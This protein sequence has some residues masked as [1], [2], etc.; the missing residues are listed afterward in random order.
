MVVSISVFGNK[1][2]VE[3]SDNRQARDRCL[4][5]ESKRILDCAVIKVNKLVAFARKWTELEITVLHKINQL[6]KDKHCMF[7]SIYRI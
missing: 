3:D 2:D 4:R 6:K 1:Q 5:S 7:S